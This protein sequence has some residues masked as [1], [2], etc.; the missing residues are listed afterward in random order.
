MRDKGHCWLKK[1]D[2]WLH[3]LWWTILTHGTRISLSMAVRDL[4]DSACL[5]QPRIKLLS[6]TVHHCYMSRLMTNQQNGMC[7]HR[8]LGSAWASVQSDQ[9][10]LFAWRKLVSLA[11]SYPFNAQRRLWSN[12][13]DAQTDPTLSWA[14][15]QIYTP[16]HK[17]WR[18]IVLYPPKILSVRPSVRQRFVS[19]L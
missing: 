9:S 3:H 2:L 16:P 14:Q 1:L 12:W 8:R 18:G 6:E 15:S 19:G 7:T 17:K 4:S 11:S 10:L 13:V 5:S